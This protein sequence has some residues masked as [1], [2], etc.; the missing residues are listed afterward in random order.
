MLDGT[1]QRYELK[2]T[3][4]DSQPTTKP[5]SRHLTSRLPELSSLAPGEREAAALPAI[6]GDG[7]SA[8]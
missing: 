4:V 8:G 2:W 1:T 6:A 3:E 7:V 5:E